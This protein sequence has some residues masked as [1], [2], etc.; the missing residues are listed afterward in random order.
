[1]PKKKTEDVSPLY[2]TEPPPSKQYVLRAMKA[3]DAKLRAPLIQSKRE[4]ARRA[5]FDEKL[6]KAN[7]QVYR[8]GGVDFAAL[9][10]EARKLWHEPRKLPRSRTRHAAIALHTPV[11]PPSTIVSPP[12]SYEWT[13]KGYVNFAPGTLS[14]YATSANGQ[15]GF[16]IA[17]SPSSGQVN[18]SYARAAVGIY[19]KPLI[20]GVLSV[21][22][23]APLQWSAS[24]N[25]AFA[26]ADGRGWAGFLVQSFN[27]NNVLSATP[28][29]QQQIVYDEFFNQSGLF[30][31]SSLNLFGGP[32][33]LS[34][35]FV[36]DTSHWYA[37]W[38]WCGGDI[39]ADGWQ[40]YLGIAKG[41]DASSQMAISV[42]YIAL[43]L[44]RVIPLR[45][46]T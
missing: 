29:D 7:I 3:I 4:S 43:T 40:Y 22:T 10:R 8:Q 18:R 39:H 11:F 25:C 5:A 46:R 21:S 32:L 9:T 44:E 16:D 30:T 42:P 15:L 26:G 2:T 35:A 27:E 45:L 34:A 28:I 23:I 19:F 17:S 13:T 14:T 37:I 38:V 36:V 33:D 41:S 6:A 24:I 12:Y 1:V 20:S 31:D